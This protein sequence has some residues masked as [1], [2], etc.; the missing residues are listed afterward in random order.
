VQW[1]A[2]VSR[3]GFLTED[4]RRLAGAPAVDRDPGVNPILGAIDAAEALLD[5]FLRLPLAVADLPH[6][7][8]KRE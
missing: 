7:L 2:K 5:E 1:T 3:S 6:G 8:G 4:F